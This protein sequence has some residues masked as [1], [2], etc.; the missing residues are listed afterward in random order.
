MIRKII[1]ALTITLIYLPQSFASYEPLNSSSFEEVSIYTPARLGFN[2]SIA[3][4]ALSDVKKGPSDNHFSLSALQRVSVN[5]KSMAFTNR[6]LYQ[7]DSYGREQTYIPASALQ[8]QIKECISTYGI[9]R[10]T[11]DSYYEQARILGY[12]HIL[13]TLHVELNP[14]DQICRGGPKNAYYQRTG[15]V[16]GQG[17][18][19]FCSRGLSTAKI[20]DITA[21]EVGHSILDVLPP[22]FYGNSDNHPYSAL[23]ESFG[24][25]SAL[26]A[27]IRLAQF[28]YPEEIPLFMENPNFCLASD[29]NGSGTCLRNPTTYRG[30]SCEAHDY[31]NYF[32]SFILNSMSKTFYYLDY[33]SENAVLTSNVFQRLLINTVVSTSSFSSLNHFSKLMIS[34]VYESS[35]DNSLN[36]LVTEIMSNELENYL[37]FMTCP[38]PRALPKA[39]SALRYK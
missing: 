11:F 20:F 37:S 15:Q 14:H 5:K 10:L 27:S 33:A 18:I 17:V 36:S 29:F 24:D 25:L 31:S 28:T 35:R 8:T 12:S 30:T 32:T 4:I 13:D 7:V 1:Y 39:Q 22:N 26:F 6:T 21:H 3:T 2:G 23:H 16:G 38:I 9:A 19:K 34:R